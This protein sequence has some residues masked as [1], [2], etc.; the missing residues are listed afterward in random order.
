MRKISVYNPL[1]ASPWDT[2]MELYADTKVVSSTT[3]YGPLYLS[4]LSRMF[5]FFAD[6]NKIYY[7]R[8]IKT[9]G[10]EMVIK[11]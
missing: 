2:K 11:V 6:I 5:F 1:L 9:V 7:S 8:E 4:A 10:N 3:S